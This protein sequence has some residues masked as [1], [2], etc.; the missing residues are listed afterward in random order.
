MRRA[1]FLALLLSGC[2]QILGLEDREL[3]AKDLDSG[4]PGV[5]AGQPIDTG[6]G[7]LPDAGRAVT[8]EEYCDLSEQL[9]TAEAGV[10]LFQT[11]DNCIAVCEK[12][13]KDPADTGNT[14]ACRLKLLRGLKSTGSNEAT[15]TCP[16]AGPGGGPPPDEPNGASCGTDCIGF[17]ALRAATC[18]PQPGD[19]NCPDRCKALV[20]DKLYNADEDFSG[21]QDTLSCRIAHLSAAALYDKTETPNAEGKKETRNNHCN[22]SGI[23]SEVQCDF[24]MKLTP[25]CESYCKIVGIACGGDNAIYENEAQCLKVCDTFNKLGEP[26]DKTIQGSRRCLRSGA[27]DALEGLN[28]GCQRAS[29]AGDGCIGGRCGSYCYFAKQ[30]CPDLYAQQYA[31]DED[32]QVK[33]NAVPDAQQNGAYAYFSTSA[34]GGRSL[35]CRLRRLTRLLEGTDTP[36]ASCPAALGLDGSA[37]N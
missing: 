34:L 19:L 29:I 1:L 16:G 12:Y 13:S 31:S 10:K 9:C 25:D 33:C 32:C 6:D 8:C 37:C 3:A 18:D 5:D 4:T 36:A 22:H 2:A 27:Y 21:G 26:K 35:Q 28:A 7:A 15:T 17:C 23:R 24:P 11:R 14:L 30:A 20:D